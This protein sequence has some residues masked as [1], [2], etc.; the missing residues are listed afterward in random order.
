MRGAGKS[1]GVVDVAGLAARLESCLGCKEALDAEGR[2]TSSEFAMQMVRAA[3][4]QSFQAD[5]GAA[6]QAAPPANRPSP[7][8]TAAGDPR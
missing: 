6:T 1:A 3:G 2:F 7:T 4:L 8:P 5:A